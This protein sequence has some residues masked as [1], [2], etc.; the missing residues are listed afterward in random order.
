SRALCA[1]LLRPKEAHDEREPLPRVAFPLLGA[2]LA[3]WFL[4]GHVAEFVGTLPAN[5]QA[6]LAPVVP[7]LVPVAAGLAGAA[8]GD[9]L[10]VVLNRTLGYAFTGVNTGFNAVTLA[11]LKAVG[12]TLRISMLVLVVYG[13]LLYLTY[14]TMTTTPSGFIPAQDKGYLLVNVQL[15]DAASLDRTDEQMRRLEEMA[16]ETPG[17]RHT[18]SVSG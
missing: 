10:R 5:W 18:V 14:H 6:F 12:A 9:F 2:A 17:V 7:W 1:L 15:P 3:Y 8:T 4:R 13:G 11:Y 16:R